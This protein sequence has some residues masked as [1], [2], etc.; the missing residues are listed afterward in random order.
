MT[1][2]DLMLVRRHL[3][4]V[5]VE[6][7]GHAHVEHCKTIADR[8]AAYIGAG[9]VS[10]LDAC[11]E[12]SQELSDLLVFRLTNKL[13]KAVTRARQVRSVEK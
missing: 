13:D 12:L 5:L 7:L 9:R 4:S 2:D 3:E 1:W 6:E 11:R 8:L 10:Q